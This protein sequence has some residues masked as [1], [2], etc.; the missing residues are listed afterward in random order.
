MSQFI[1]KNYSFVDNVASFHYGFDDGRDFTETVTFNTD[2]KGYD[3]DLLDKALQL[4]FVIIG[5]SYYKTFPT[6]SVHL[7]FALDQS[8][9][10]F[11]NHVYQ[12]GLSQFAFENDLTRAD[13]ATFEFQTDD[14]AKPLAYQG[15]GTVALQSG[16]KDSL[17]VAS[18][19]KEKN[20][21]FSSWYVSS[22]ARHPHIL[23]DVGAQLITSLRSIDRIALERA[24][25]DGAKNG[26][27][28]VTY[29]LESLAVIQAI[30]LGKNEIIVSIAHEGEEPHHHIGD[31]AVTH[32]WSKTWRAEQDFA[33]YVTRYIS[34]DIHIG[35]PLRQY[36]E[37][38]VAELFVEHTWDKY[39]HAF[40]SCNVANYRQGNDNTT[41]K[42]CGDC[43]KC[44]NS[45]VLFAPFLPAE[46][47]KSLFHGQDLFSKPSLTH[48]FK[49]LMGIDNVAKPF[50]CVGEIDELRLAYHMAQARG[51]YGPLPFEVPASTFDYK[52]TYPSQ[53]WATEMLQ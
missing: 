33:E 23:D 36:S 51:G 37:L 38:R 41:L 40:S 27:V 31:L 22:G 19:L 17:F 53:A 42:W 35:S 10:N 8:Q 12:E 34:P 9:A 43:P 26:H 7:D 4:A 50:E 28:P 46:E 13:L 14:M 18:L 49:G 20:L 45:F 29:I 39:G 21:P 30:L 11:F 44:A 1:F 5:T 25:R 15:S 16:G 32:Q 52:Q 6:K 2:D 24:G 3:E 48:T 47:L